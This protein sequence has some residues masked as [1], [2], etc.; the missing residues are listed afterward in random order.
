M[1]PARLAQVCA[2]LGV[3][4]VHVSSGCIYDGYEK[5]FT[6]EDPPNFCWEA[7]KR[8][9]KERDSHLRSSFYSSSKTM[10]AIKV[11]AK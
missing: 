5:D 4:L 11:C 1:F 10:H 9:W 3:K 8:Y 6:E 7:D 2:N